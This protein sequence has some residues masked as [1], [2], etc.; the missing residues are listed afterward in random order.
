M[1]I[2][3][4]FVQLLLYTKQSVLP[5]NMSTLKMNQYI[6]IDIKHSRPQSA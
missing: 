1:V 4:R 5:Y 2:K 6:A 3:I